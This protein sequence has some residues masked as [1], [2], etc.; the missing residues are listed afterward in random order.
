MN[1]S[2]ELYCPKKDIKSYVVCRITLL[3]GRYKQILGE[4]QSLFSYAAFILDHNF[5][6]A[7]YRV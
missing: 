3:N 5:R 7:L 1:G 2:L 4:Y 6:L